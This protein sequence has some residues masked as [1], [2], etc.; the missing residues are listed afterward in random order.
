MESNM[1]KFFKHSN[2]RRPHFK[3]GNCIKN[4][5]FFIE[6]DSTSFSKNL[7]NEL[8]QFL[9]E[10]IKPF[11]Q[12][13]DEDSALLKQV[14]QMFATHGWLGACI[15]KSYGGLQ[16]NKEDYHRFKKML[17]YHSGAL[18][19]LQTQHQTAAQLIQTSDNTALK[20]IYLS[21]MT[22]GRRLV[23]MA[24][25]PHLVNWQK[26]SVIA[27]VEGE[28][29]FIQKANIRMATGY[30]FF[31]EL[32]I[33]FVVQEKT[34][35][36]YE[37]TA[38]V[39]F[40]TTQQTSGGKIAYGKPL[41]LLAAQ[42][43]NTVSVDIEN[44]FIPLETVIK[45]QPL[46]SFA[47][48]SLTHTNLDSYLAGLIAALLDLAALSQPTGF[49]IEGITTFKNQLAIYEQLILNRETHTPVAQIRAL[50]IELCDAC[51]AFTR[52]VLRGR[53]MLK[54]DL[55]SQQFRRLE[56]E[57]DLYAVVT[58]H[59]DLLEATLELQ[60]QNH[61]VLSSEWL[62]CLQPKDLH[63]TSLRL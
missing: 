25:S 44:W 27:I 39:P 9:I 24:L 40:Q 61:A 18:T 57:R 58:A 8:Q 5:T 49:I 12:T 19:F 28:G 53:I 55:I 43:T 42:S 36:D 20:D 59:N 41:N 48:K 50:G 17:A 4:A 33:G 6:N 62:N 21:Q 10:S 35:P 63:T 26:P 60:T 34:G 29:F 13:I 16:L 38:C 11:A 14:F 52:Q 23:G 30:D 56:H 46:G 2:R 47:K 32:I 15:P 37:V 31:S 7:F 51:I 45:V 3:T 54:N 22:D 1:L